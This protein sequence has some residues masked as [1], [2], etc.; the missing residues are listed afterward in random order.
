M[1]A[2]LL[3]LALFASVAACDDEVIPPK[4]PQKTVAVK[5]ATPAERRDAA[6]KA[7]QLPPAVTSTPSDAS[8]ETVPE[9]AVVRVDVDGAAD[10]AA[11]RATVGIA[12]GDTVTTAKAQDAI[13]KLYA[14]GGADD[15]RLLARREGQG[16]VLHFTVVKRPTFGEVVI[17]GGT[18]YDA[19]ELEKA[20]SATAGAT[21]DPA[22]IVATRGKLVDAL[23]ER[24]YADAALSIVGARAQD[25][26]VDLC[27]DLKEGHKITL[28]SITFQGLKKI[29]ESE[30]R[31][32]IDTESG[33]I[34]TSGGI[35]DQNKLD[36]AIS[37]MAEIFD[38]QGLAKGRI[39]TKTT[40]NGDKVSL[41]FDV[42][43]GPVVRLRRYEVK[44]ALVADAGAYKKLLSLKPKDPF[45]RA[46]LVADL[47]KIAELHEKKG[48][49]DL[50]VQPQVQ[51]DDKN[52]TVDVVLMVIDPKKAK[53]APPPPPPKKK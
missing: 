36:E 47:Q 8:S 30:L 18:L 35:L 1:R 51:P 53:Q 13:R 7:Q 4:A 14:L 44:G 11:A 32:T 42:E 17:H 31:A 39:S 50:V 43:E 6:C 48:R 5:Q 23:H 2:Q 22:A 20:L 37:K 41:L 3:A 19:P 38:A 34:N 40:R 9:G 45:S 28:D 29:K 52:D 25:G 21:Y 46:K 15:V 33:R 12:P 26:S 49:K 27:V 24:G 16:V 10:A